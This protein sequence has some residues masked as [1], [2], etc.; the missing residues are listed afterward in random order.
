MLSPPTLRV[1]LL[2]TR[3]EPGGAQVHVRDLVVGLGDRVDFHVGVGDDDWLAAELRAAGVPLT[4]LP[5]LQREIA[6][7]PDARAVR[8]IRALVRQVRPDLV[9]THSTKAGLLGRLAAR[10]TD[11]PGLHTAHAWS[12]S[13][14][15]SWKRKAM[16]IP[17]EALA[18]R[19]TGRFI[20]V[21]EADREIGLRY[22]VARDPQVRV[23]HN[24]VPD[25]DLR[26]DPAAGAPPR[27]IMV[28]RLAAPK[29]PL[30]LLEALAG[31]SAPF[32]LDLV[33]DGPDM[34]AVQAAVARHGLAD[35]VTLLGRRT[36][37][38]VLLSRAQVFALISQQEGFPLAI[39]E[40]MRAGLPVL[41]SDVGGVRE[42]V[43][44]GVTGH[45]IP[46]GDAATLRGHL[47]RLLRAAPLRAQMGAAGRA[48]FEARFTIS[49]ML[50]RTLSVY[51]ELV[52]RPAA[53]PPPQHGRLP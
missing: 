49:E 16:A 32:H 6:A 14:G 9:H 26:A 15:L 17:L 34:A 8:A 22:H 20:V 3:G 24:G 10:S 1:L 31:V 44:E 23:V 51:Q 12:F 39:L 2:I 18:G 5:D 11:V 40:A 19:I 42:A 46:R 41:A 48:A 37:V 30:L 4:V 28:A 27:L 35:R 33:G 36:D 38:P 25:T 53:P 47:D 13:D 50:R 21:S 45:L 29:D 43:D 52:G 7:G